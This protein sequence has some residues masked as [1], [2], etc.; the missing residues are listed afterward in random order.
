MAIRVVYILNNK[1]PDI[2]AEAKSWTFVDGWLRLLDG[3]FG[4]AAT[5]R[6]IEIQKDYVLS[7][8]YVKLENDP[9]GAPEAPEVPEEAAE[10]KECR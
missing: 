1:A 2:V 5:R 4:E 3:E 8:E 10:V 9:K 7:V 6:L